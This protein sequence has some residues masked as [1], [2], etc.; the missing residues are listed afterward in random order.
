MAD[1]IARTF[2]RSGATRA[3]ALDI[4]K[5]FDRF[6]HAGHAG[7][8][9]KSYG[10]LVQILDLICSFPSSDIGPYLFFSQ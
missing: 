6:W 5:T 7:R 4:S 9:L 8:N 1:R 2:S 3:V 10:I